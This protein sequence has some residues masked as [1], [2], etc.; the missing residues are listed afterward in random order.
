MMKKTVWVVSPVAAVL[1]AMLLAGLPNVRA[2]TQQPATAEVKI[3]NFS[4]APATL[5]VAVGTTVT[6]T[7][8]DDIPHTAVSSVTRKFSSPKCS[9]R[10]KSSPTPSPKPGPIPTTARSIRR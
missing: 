1:I 9:T 6:W 5:T 2:K 8:R 3:D 10:M 7:N 4:S